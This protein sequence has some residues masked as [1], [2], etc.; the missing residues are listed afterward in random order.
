MTT[1][2]KKSGLSRRDL[3]KK[4]AVA[5]AIVWTVPMI[6]TVPAYAATGSTISTACSYFVLVYTVTNP[7]TGVG[8]T[9]ADRI[10]NTGSCAGNTTSADVTWCYQCSS[11]MYDNLAP[12]NAIRKDGILLASSGCAANSYFT[13]SGNTITPNANV[14]ID[15]AVAHAGS[16]NTTTGQEPGT[17]PSTA[18]IYPYTCDE[19][20]TGLQGKV[21]VACGP[22]TRASFSCLPQSP[23]TK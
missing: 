3:I 11:G 6:E 2:E 21:N 13:V 7:L 15:F 19:S 18:L 5:G 8:L 1:E 14:T 17:P 16:L 12:Q 23:S 4:G 10:T 22:L 9:Y 20:P